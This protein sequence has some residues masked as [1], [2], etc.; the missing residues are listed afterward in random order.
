MPMKL[1]SI[2]I[3]F[4]TLLISFTLPQLTYSHPSDAEEIRGVWL[5][6]I[7]SEVLFSTQKTQSAIAL[8]KEANFNTVYPT[9]WNWG[10]TL[11]PSP[12][13]EK[14][15][16]TKIDPE[17]GLQNRDI[18]QEIITEGHQKQ[19][20]V[21][22]WF[23]FGFMAP[24]DSQLAQ[25]HPSWITNRIDNSNIWLEGGVHERVWLNP[26]HPE[27]Q[28][29]ITD[30]V[31]EIVTNYDI[32]GIQFDDHFGYPSDLGYDPYTTRLYRQEHDGRFPPR[33]FANQEWIQWRADKITDYVETLHHEIKK[34]KPDV[35][36]SISPNPQKFSLE[37]YLLDW[38]K[39]EEMGL[40][41]ELLVQVYRDNMI[42]FN[43]EIAQA[44]IQ[45]AKNN[46]PTAVGIL[47]GLKGRQV[48]LNIMEEQIRRTR[49]EGYGGVAFFFYESLWNF[50][51]ESVEMRK[52][53]F[54]NIFS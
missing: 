29:F 49:Q 45:R 51:P 3:F 11:Y 50:G 34:V 39:W 36:V 32:D 30:L 37:K 43:R 21:I 10:Y 4:C 27:V 1:K 14:V 44:D 54:K 9:V 24:A 13:A 42:A 8:L 38:A 46:I 31:M 35:L 23:E 6:N 2:I 28:K 53:F 41:D 19:L 52:D 48:S 5:T 33:D 40:I 25:Q 16:G 20:K 7:D 22:P 18:L 17:E 15:T 47:S 26:L 12:V